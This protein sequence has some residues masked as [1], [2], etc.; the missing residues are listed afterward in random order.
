LNLSGRVI[1]AYFYTHTHKL[2]FSPTI[3]EAAAQYSS[4]T[5]DYRLKNW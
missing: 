3:Q 4:H 2:I 5:I 1:P